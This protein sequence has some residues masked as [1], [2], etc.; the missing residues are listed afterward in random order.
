MMH[1]RV[2]LFSTAGLIAAP[3]PYNQLYGTGA[4]PPAAQVEPV[5]DPIFDSWKQGF[6]LRA[7]AA[8]LPADRV[9]EVLAGITPDP[10]VLAADQRQPELSRSMGDYLAGAVSQNRIDGGARR[11]AEGA[12]WMEPI[13]EKHGVPSEILVSI[14]AIESNF[15]Q[16]QGDYDV[17]RSLATLA[18]EGRRRTFGEA[19]LQAALKIVFRGDAPRERLKGSWAG[20]MGQTQFTPEDYLNYAVDGDGDGLR[21]IW[22]SSQDSLS[23]SAN[24]LARK[25]AWRRGQGWAK[26][27]VL[28]KDGSF[29]YSLAEGERQP[30][31]WWADKGVRP[32]DGQAWSQADASEA[33]GLILPAGWSGPAFLVLPNHFAIR[34]YNNATTYALAVGLL[35]DRIAGRPGVIAQWPAETPLT[36]AD[37]VA[38]QQALAALGFDVG[39]PDG[40]L[41]IK[42]RAATRAWQRSRSMPADGYL[43]YGLIQALKTQAGIGPAAL[44]AAPAS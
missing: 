39:E 22:G 15:G 2:F 35:A 6:I 44:P 30:Y 14:W 10:R 20:A 21:D 3:I 8:G 9:S 12:G 5:G 16:N 26:E 41:G 38:A 19:Q 32:A 29:D 17:V 28:P 18:A 34:A 25:A 11:R 13:A 23:S 33:A 1:R 37:R 36:L 7:T 31:Q 40:V 42:T 24:F 43:T 4:L 27:V